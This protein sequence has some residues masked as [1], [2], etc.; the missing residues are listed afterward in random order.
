MERHLKYLSQNDLL[1]IGRYYNFLVQGKLPPNWRQ[2][3]K[4]LPPNSPVLI[5]LYIANKLYQS[6][7]QLPW[8][9]PITPQ[10]YKSIHSILHLSPEY[11]AENRI[12]MERIFRIWRKMHHQLPK[13]MPLI[14]RGSHQLGDFAWMIRRPE[15]SHILFI[16]NDNQEQFLA[17]H[18]QGNPGSGACVKGGGNAA[19][20]P[21]QCTN[22]PRAA[23]IPTGVQG[24]GYNSLTEG[25]KYIDMAID[26]IE[27]L[28]DTDQYLAVAYSASSDGKS[29]GTGIFSPV[30]EVKEYI[31]EQLQS[32]TR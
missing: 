9:T 2:I 16:F 18:R 26:Y 29:L 28:I 13:L 22:P 32:L 17:F 23:G 6:K 1:E 14:Y 21:Y 24:R 4:N 8:N 7:I 15:Y 31:V 3:I 11:T 12:R 19:I 25:K 20:R 30:E 10:L 27:D 5:D